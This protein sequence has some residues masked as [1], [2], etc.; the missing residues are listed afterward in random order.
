MLSLFT[1]AT[2]IIKI[3][4]VIVIAYLLGSLNIAIIVTKLFTG[5]DIRTMGS[6]NAGFTNVMRSVGTPAGIITFVGDFMKCVIAAIIG[7]LIFTTMSS[8]TINVTELAGYGKYLGGMFSFIGHIYP[9]YFKFKGGKGVVTMAA[10]AAVINFPVFAITFVVFAT[11][12]LCTRIISISSI[13]SAAVLAATTFLVTYFYNFKY[14][15]EVSFEYV[16]IVS[17]L[18]LAMSAT[19]IIKHKSNIQRLL[20]GEEKKLT[21]KKKDK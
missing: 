18:T 17:I 1:D 3:I 6:G 4:A 8:D 2:N 21:L 20:K 7:G 19:L 14:L 9:I 12:F 5:K 10:L 11:I 15:G 16:V 13:I